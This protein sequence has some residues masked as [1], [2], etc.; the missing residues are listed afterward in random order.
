MPQWQSRSQW[1]KGLAAWT[2]LC[3]ADEPSGDLPSV[4]PEAVSA[5][6][7]TSEEGWGGGHSRAVDEG[8]QA[9]LIDDVNRWFRGRLKSGYAVRVRSRTEVESAAIPGGNADLAELRR[10]IEKLRTSATKK[11]VI[12]VPD[13]QSIEVQP[14]DVGTGISQLLPVVVLAVWARKRLVA[15]EQPELHLHPALQTELADLFLESALERES[16]LLIETH[17]E[18]II[19]RLL[20]RIRET[21]EGRL[22]PSAH[23]LRPEQVSVIYAERTDQGT[24][25]S[26]LRIH[27]T[28]EF[29]DRWPHGFFAE[30]VDELF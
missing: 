10:F 28:G 24:K 19:L 16:R 7:E 30:R 4:S 6:A 25:L 20:R 18:H 5:V 23:P 29:I 1:A 12:L 27:E 22:P 3:E 21:T 2:A 9:S 15:I 11:K 17:S 13:G 8:G 26:Q 14:H